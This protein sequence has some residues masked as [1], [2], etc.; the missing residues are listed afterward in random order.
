[1]MTAIVRQTMV[2]A[3]T[4]V[5]GSSLLGSHAWANLLDRELQDAAFGL[6][7]EIERAIRSGDPV[8]RSAQDFMAPEISIR[9]RRPGRVRDPESD[10][11]VGALAKL[12]KVA[13]STLASAVRPTDPY[14]KA[15]NVVEG[16]LDSDGVYHPA[17]KRAVAIVSYFPA[18]GRATQGQHRKPQKGRQAEISLVGS[19][20]LESPK[21][22][23]RKI[24]QYLGIQKRRLYFIPKGLR[25]RYP[26]D[27]GSSRAP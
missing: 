8:N 27:T 25:A 22:R 17:S 10:L 6:T 12:L 13:T 2:A 23:T 3:F 14:G 16:V 21:G 11:T 15:G 18:S 9:V 7:C 1:M 4:L 5:A 26:V 19:V 20:E 24:L